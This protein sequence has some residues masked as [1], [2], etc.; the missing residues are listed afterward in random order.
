MLQ[1]P[2]TLGRMLKHRTNKTPD[3]KAIGWIENNEVKSI[4]FSQYKNIIETFLK[5]TGF[6]KVQIDL[7]N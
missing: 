6:K 5:N 4:S 1:G 7:K 2:R 3:N